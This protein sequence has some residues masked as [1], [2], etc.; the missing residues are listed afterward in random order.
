MRKALQVCIFASAT[1][2]FMGCG[3]FYETIEVVQVRKTKITKITPSY[4]DIVLIVKL[5]N[6]NGFSVT[7]NES[8]LQVSIDGQKVG[9]ARIDREF[10]I[11]EDTSKYYQISLRTDFNDEFSAVLTQFVDRAM[12][13]RITAHVEGTL[14]GEVFVFSRKEQIDL[15]QEITF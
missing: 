2:I 5:N 9:K 14:T 8:D 4:A 1:W 3:F 10:T 15:T 11:L 13:E 7:V 12:R 6:P